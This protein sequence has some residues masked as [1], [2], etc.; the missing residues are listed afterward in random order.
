MHVYIKSISVLWSYKKHLSITCNTC[1]KELILIRCI[2]S[3]KRI[4][5]RVIV[6]CSDVKCIFLANIRILTVILWDYDSI[7]SS[8][9][10]TSCCS[11]RACAV[12]ARK[13]ARQ[14]SLCQ[15]CWKILWNINRHQLIKNCT[16]QQI[17]NLIKPF[18]VETFMIIIFAIPQK[19]WL[20]KFVL[21]MRCSMCVEVKLI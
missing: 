9:M 1:R 17:Q 2:Q 6:T 15:Y 12:L 4:T 8:L 21:W 13:A 16:N 18:N 20:V 10:T 3:K 7:F 19:Q 14:P 11:I 5:Q